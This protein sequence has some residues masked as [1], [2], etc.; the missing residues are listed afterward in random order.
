MRECD[1]LPAWQSVGRQGECYIAVLSGA[2]CATITTHAH[3]GNIQSMIL[4]SGA[5]FASNEKIV[6]RAFSNAETRHD[7]WFQGQNLISPAL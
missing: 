2:K 3:S 4:C 5:D 7:L 1:S 6:Q